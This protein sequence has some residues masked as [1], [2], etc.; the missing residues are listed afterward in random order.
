MYLGYKVV[1]YMNLISVSNLTYYLGKKKIFDNISLSINDDS[2]ITIAGSNSSGKTTLL[3]LLS[4][5]LMTENIIQIDNT[6]INSEN[7]EIIDKKVCLFSINNKYYSKTVLYEL[8]LDSKDDSYKSINKIKS[9]LIEF[10]LINYIDESPQVL[11]YIERQKISLIKALLKESKVLLLDNIFCYF[12]KYSKIEFITL[13]K[14][15]QS[16]YNFSIILTINNL[17]D[18]IFSDRLIVIDSESILLDGAPENIFKEEKLLK[19]VGLNV[20]INYEL[21]SKLRLYDLIEGSSF[22]IDDMVNELCK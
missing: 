8:L 7:K 10:G 12:D 6:L 20:P 9:Y 18:S 2:F 1:K 16:I 15:Y 5:N 19:L 4:G 22:D 13:L 21:Y 3:K 14:K 11:N 17:E